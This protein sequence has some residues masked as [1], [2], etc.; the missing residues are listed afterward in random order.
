[1]KPDNTPGQTENTPETPTAALHPFDGAES[2]PMHFW[3][4]DECRERSGWW[5]LPAVVIGLACLV[6]L[7]W[8][9]W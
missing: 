5:I 3:D 9:G 1:M 2:L 7:G 8:W 6:A 4:D